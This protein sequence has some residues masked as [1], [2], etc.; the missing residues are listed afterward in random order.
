MGLGQCF[1]SLELRGGGLRAFLSTSRKL[2]VNRWT[3]KVIAFGLSEVVADDLDGVQ[4]SS[5]VEFLRAMSSGQFVLHG[6]S[7]EVNG[8]SSR[9]VKFLLRKF[10]YVKHLSVYGV[11]DT[12][13]SFEIVHIKPEIR[14]EKE[15][16]EALKPTMSLLPLYHPVNPFLTKYRGQTQPAAKR[17][18]ITSHSALLVSNETNKTPQSQ[19]GR[20][21]DQKKPNNFM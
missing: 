9:R 7:I 20:C 11:L 21:Q 3:T 10:L 19:S 6:K 5:L 13:G 14:E 16:H 4:V 15:E 12:A 18:G 2:S 17:P 1:E 8:L